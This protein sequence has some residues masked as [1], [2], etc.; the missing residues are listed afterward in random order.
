[1]VIFMLF[2]NLGGSPNNGVWSRFR[3]S[4]RWTYF[5]CYRSVDVVL[6]LGF[7]SKCNLL[8]RLVLW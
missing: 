1:M 7:V 4:G 8:G 5:A 2:A 6:S 3:W